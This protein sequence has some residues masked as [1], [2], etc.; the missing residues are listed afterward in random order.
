M[1]RELNAHLWQLARKPFQKMN[2]MIGLA[3][4]NQKM[5][6]KFTRAVSQAVTKFQKF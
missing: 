3:L 6:P 2:C 4:I 5:T 1:W